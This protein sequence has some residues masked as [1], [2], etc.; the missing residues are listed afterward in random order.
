MRVG[1]RPDYV[2]L[3]TADEAAHFL[4]RY[5]AISVNPGAVEVRGGALGTV[6]QVAADSEQGVLKAV[7]S[8][9]ALP[10]E[11]GDQARLSAA[12]GEHGMPV[13]ALR[14]SLIGQAIV[15][16]GSLLLRYLEWLPGDLYET[17]NAGQ[18][19]SA[20]IMLARLHRCPAEL[21]ALASAR[22]RPE[23]EIH[24]VRE[25][26]QVLEAAASASHG[27]GKKWSPWLS[28]LARRTRAVLPEL[29]AA[30]PSVESCLC[31]GDF[32]GQNV[33]FAGERVCALY[34]LDAV[35]VGSHLVDL[36]YALAFFPAV[37]CSRP[38]T[39]REIQQFTD[40]YATSHTLCESDRNLLPAL[41]VAA[42]AK[43]VALWLGLCNHPRAEAAVSSW[44]RAYRDFPESVTTG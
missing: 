9:S 28:G 3:L 39:D 5:W 44:L 21:T 6:V 10:A 14:P 8:R 24:R 36:A 22:R 43:G 7:R 19:T 1:V 30:L 20:A 40:A 31:H 38:F 12:L 17:G 37:L 35:H 33:G 32:R 15:V 26:A 27:I 29:S 25:A 23:H 41:L 11:L 34:D 18:L 13:P 2:P 16:H 42:L 4:A